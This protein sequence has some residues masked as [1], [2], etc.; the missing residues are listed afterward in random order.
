MD[1]MGYEMTCKL[2]MKVALQFNPCRSFISNYLHSSFVQCRR[3]WKQK[4]NR[5]LKG[6]PLF[7]Q[8]KKFLQTY[9]L[10]LKEL[11]HWNHGECLANPVGHSVRLVRKTA[12]FLAHNSPA[13]IT[14]AKMLMQKT[15][16]DQKPKANKLSS[17]Q[18]VQACWVTAVHRVVVGKNHGL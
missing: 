13:C 11:L 14:T 6:A 8:D 16:T 10:Q 4:K 5:S 12:F 15:L 17:L 3:W 1:A 2:M 18:C 7:F 9:Q